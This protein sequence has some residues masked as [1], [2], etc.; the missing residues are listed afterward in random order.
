MDLTVIDFFRVGLGLAAGLIVGFG[1]GALQERA[2]RRH[3]ALEA[4]GQFKNAWSVMPGS[5]ARV[6][7][8][9]LTLVAI[10]FV[11]PLLF[12][13]GTQWWVSAGVA[14]GYGWSLLRSLRRRPTVLRAWGESLLGGERAGRFSPLGELV[15]DDDSYERA[16]PADWATGA[17]MLVSAECLR[18]V[19]AWDE[20][21]FL[22][23]EE[24]DFALRAWDA[25]YRLVYVPAAHAVHLEGESHTS[26][27]LYALLTSKT[28][29]GH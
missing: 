14:A 7:Y 9:L 26:P 29:G 10:Q 16:G 12:A 20:S 21:Y 19:G 1:F 27:A 24:T 13:D 11:C 6:A 3:E 4:Q 23:S 22:Y 28:N 2:R 5:G 17:A 18:D 25:G 8:L 15:L